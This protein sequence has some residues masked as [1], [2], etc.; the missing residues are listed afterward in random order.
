MVLGASI[1]ASLFSISD[2]IC[3]IAITYEAY[4]VVAPATV[5]MERNFRDR[6]AAVPLKQ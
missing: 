4:A 6:T 2:T 1:G 5:F 3:L